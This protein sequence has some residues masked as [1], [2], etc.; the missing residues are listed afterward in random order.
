MLPQRLDEKVE[1]LVRHDAPPPAQQNA[2]NWALAAAGPAPGTDQVAV[3]ALPGRRPN[4]LQT[5]G[6]LEQPGN[7]L[8]TAREP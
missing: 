1:K 8:E 5:N 3:V 6:A 7:A 2:A 4:H